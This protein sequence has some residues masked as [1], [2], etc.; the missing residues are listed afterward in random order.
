MNWKPYIDGFACAACAGSVIFCA[1]LSKKCISDPSP[2]PFQMEEGQEICM[3]LL[4]PWFW[5]TTFVLCVI[6]SVSFLLLVIFRNRD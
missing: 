3:T 6:L 4:P 2:P 1:F 5:L